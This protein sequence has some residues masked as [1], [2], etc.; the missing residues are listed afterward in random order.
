MSE[1]NY[2]ALESCLQALET[3]ADPEA[4][5]MQYPLLADE[6]RPVLFAARAA[7][8]LAVPEVPAKVMARGRARLLGHAARLRGSVGSSRAPVLWFPRLAVSLA[9]ALIF[10]LSGTGLVRAST[11]ALPGDDLYPVKRTWEGVR[12]LA[13]FDPARRKIL[14]SQF[15][16]LRVE[17]VMALLAEGRVENISF[18]GYLIRIEADEWLVSGIPVLIDDQTTLPVQPVTPGAR[19]MVEGRTTA[20]GVVEADRVV[21][22]SPGRPVSTPI[23]P[24]E[25]ERIDLKPEANENEAKSETSLEDN[26]NKNEDPANT[27]DGE[28]RD[29]NENDNSGKKGKDDEPDPPDEPDGD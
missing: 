28:R 27:N 23:P 6:L 24:A 4:V 16:Q 3:G 10:I 13:R 7:Q 29:D 20:Q 5:L 21:L 15:A 19:L 17:E 1:K 18:N 25:T 22:L 8:S 11:K 2:E 12:L 14:E 9:V 26:E